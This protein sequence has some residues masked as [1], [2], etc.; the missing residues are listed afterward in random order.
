VNELGIDI[1]HHNGT[2][3]WEIAKSKGVK[4]V[5]LKASESNWYV[6]PMFAQNYEL[7][8]SVGLDV[9]CY[10]FF[11]GNATPQTQF[12]LLF[13][14]IEGLD[15]QLPIMLDCETMDGMSLSK[16]ENRLAYMVQYILDKF[17]QFPGIY[18]SKGFWKITREQWN[19]LPLW[20]ANWYVDA[21]AIPRP[22]TDWKYWQFAKTKGSDFGVQS[23]E[24]CVDYRKVEEPPTP[25]PPPAN[26]KIVIGSIVLTDGTEWKGTLPKIEIGKEMK[27]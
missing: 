24:V 14:V 27:R 21:P 7:A 6:D 22:W 11:R 25:P 1:S 26:D 20:I 2:V 12:S 15:F 9:G 16:Y 13:D 23:K 18:T 5:I 17:G 19:K 10:H 4:F 3:D 8:R